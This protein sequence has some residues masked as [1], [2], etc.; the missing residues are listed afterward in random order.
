MIYEARLTIPPST[1]KAAAVRES[2]DV[3]PGTAQQVGIEFPTG[4]A[5]LVH[6][7]VLYQEQQVW[8]SN[9]DQD[10]SGDGALLVFPEDL[11]LDAS[12]Y[13]I[14]L[15]GWSDDDTFNHTVTLR[16]AVVAFGQT[17]TEVLAGMFAVPGRE[18]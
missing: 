12:P 4:C 18:L 3:H 1:S 6:L 10:F 15:E 9:L 8:P 17:V 5:G 14:S 11:S 7:R 16:L 13:T 2:F